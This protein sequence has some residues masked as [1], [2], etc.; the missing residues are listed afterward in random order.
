MYCLKCR[1]VIE[2]ENFTTATSE[3]GILMRR[4]QCITCG[5]TNIQFTKRDVT[6]GSFLNALV[7]KL[8]FKM[9]FTEHNFTGLGTKLYKRLNSDGTPNEW[10]IPINRVDNAAYH[11]Y[12]CYSKH[13][14]TKT[15]NEVCDKIM[16]GELN[17]IVNPTLRE[18]IDK[19]IVGKLIKAKVN[20]GLGLPIKKK[21]KNLLMSLQRNITNQSLE[22][23]REMESM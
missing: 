18:R 16:L 23:F 2:T 17:G 3:N 19:S 10:S 1:R 9:H 5:K 13:D 22:N 4:G 20:F 12:L 7:K 14:D 11:H 15:R 8:S 6:G 21:F